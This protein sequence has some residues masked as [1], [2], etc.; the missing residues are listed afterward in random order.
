MEDDAGDGRQ[1]YLDDVGRRLESWSARIEALEALAAD[2]DPLTKADF[3]EQIGELWSRLDAARERHAQL[4]EAG[5]ESWTACRS[6]CDQVWS[7][8]EDAY[9]ELQRTFA[10]G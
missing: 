4:A 5:E 2:A 1:R 7:E 6:A 9:G 8:V 3:E 10:R